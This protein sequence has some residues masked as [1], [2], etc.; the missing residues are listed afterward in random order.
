VHVILIARVRSAS[1]LMWREVNRPYAGVPGAGEWVH[2]FDDER[3]RTPVV[4]VEHRNS[5]VVELT[6]GELD[7]DPDE[8]RAYGWQVWPPDDG[9]A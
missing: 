4:E 1:A 5:G 9:E 2:I 8:L 6:L 3:L 7:A